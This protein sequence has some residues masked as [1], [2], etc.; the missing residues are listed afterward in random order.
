MLGRGALTIV[1][2]LFTLS[3]LERG[4]AG[5]LDRNRLHLDGIVGSKD[6]KLIDSCRL[7]GYASCPLGDLRGCLGEHQTPLYRRGL[8][9]LTVNTYY[10]ILVACASSTRK[11]SE[12]RRARTLP[13]RLHGAVM[14]RSATESGASKSGVDYDDRCRGRGWGD[15][16]RGHVFSR[17]GRKADGSNCRVGG[18]L[19]KHC[20]VM[21]RCATV[22]R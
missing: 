13:S 9:T 20:F 7:Q 21:T 3:P 5:Y 14:R 6:P 22:T 4:E 16:P 2:A 15:S 1:V 17:E 10:Y 11:T 12:G 8:A 18:W 19:L